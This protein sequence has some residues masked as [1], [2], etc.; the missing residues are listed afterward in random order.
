MTYEPTALEAV[1]IVGGVGTERPNASSSGPPTS[2]W[3]TVRAASPRSAPRRSRLARSPRGCASAS[4]MRPTTCSSPPPRA[5]ALEV[6][7]DNEARA[8]TAAIRAF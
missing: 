6:L 5:F 1:R 3:P 7:D 8:S 2:P 4:E